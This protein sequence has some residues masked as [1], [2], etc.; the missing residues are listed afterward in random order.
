MRRQY[1][2]MISLKH[3][4]S[5][6]R[7]SR[8]LSIFRHWSQC[9]QSCSSGNTGTITNSSASSQKRG[10]SIVESGP[11]IL[12]GKTLSASWSGV[13]KVNRRRTLS[14]V[15]SRCQK[16]RYPAGRK[17][18][19]YPT[20]RNEGKDQSIQTDWRSNVRLSRVSAHVFSTFWAPFSEKRFS[21]T[22][23]KLIPFGSAR[24]K[25]TGQQPSNRRS[26]RKGG[27]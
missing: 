22:D 11:G 1:V 4:P 14:F 26:P 3:P 25:S 6:N 27:D 8:N 24:P 13:R 21:S 10:D 9:S 16:L 12:R 7:S 15:N 23:R 18:A 20:A 5:A 17:L 19:N 2:L